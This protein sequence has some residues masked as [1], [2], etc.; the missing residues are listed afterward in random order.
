MFY[1]IS[2]KCLVVFVWLM[3]TKTKPIQYVMLQHGN[4]IQANPVLSF[5]K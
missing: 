1:I 3:E 2:I 4:L 5:L